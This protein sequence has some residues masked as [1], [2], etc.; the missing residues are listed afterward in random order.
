MV[1]VTVMKHLIIF[2]AVI[3]TSLSQLSALSLNPA[4]EIENP[5]SSENM[6]EGENFLKGY[7]Q[8]EE[9]YTLSLVTIGRGDPLYIWFGHTSLVVA[10][11]ESGREVMY[12]FGIFSFSEGFYTSF[13][14][15]R[16]WYETWATDAP[17]RVT[18]AAE[19][20][21]EVSR[22]YLQLP[23]E[24]I[25]SVLRHLN[26]V[27]DS[28][29]STYLYHHYYENCSTRIRDIIDTATGG[30]LKTWAQAQVYPYTIRQI[31]AKST[32]S[33]PFIHWTLNFLQSGVIDHEITLWD[34]MFLPRIMEEALLSFSY[35]D[36]NG[37]STPLAGKREILAEELS[38]IRPDM[39]QS[40]TR[41]NM[42]LSGAS[43]LIALIT[44]VLKRIRKHNRF[45]GPRRFATFL[46]GLITS[47]WSLYLSIL[48]IILLF[49]MVATTHDVTYFNENIFLV[50][51]L[52]LF[53]LFSSVPFL[54]GYGGNMERL[55]KLNSAALA[56]VMAGFLLKL[57]FPE[58]LIQDN[59]DI[60]LLITP[61]FAVNSSWAAPL[62]KEKRR[63]I[64]DRTW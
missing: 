15:G 18:L 19:E 47:L 1:E 6:L 20:E 21:R 51:P 24:V 54:K 39:N 32:A 48:S 2:L 33:N 62:L 34:A 13:A 8:D 38:G 64:N 57:I 53:I 46:F 16:L 63:E 5:N 52:V 41:A 14:L 49:M 23:Q 59:G 56:L 61:L 40:R 60:F 35:T 37:V 4:Y 58:F 50:S 31:V 36:E 25:I 3:L 44:I 22:I 30:Q 45:E 29:H 7:A 11:R 55:E 43:L 12:D 17:M 9:R 28:E 26:K 42:Y 10:D 27:T